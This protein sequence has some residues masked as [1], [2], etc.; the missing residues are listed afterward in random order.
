MDDKQKEYN[1][2]IK[3]FKKRCEKWN[4]NAAENKQKLKVVYNEDLDGKNISEIQ[5][6]IVADNP[7]EKEWE[8]K[9]YLFDSRDDKKRAGYIAHETFR[10]LKLDE[11]MFL[12]LNKTPIFTPKS[13]NLN[14]Y[15]ESPILQES[16]EYMAE[17]TFNI[18]KINSSIQTIV[19]GIGDCFDSDKEKFDDGE[20]FSAYYKKIA[21]LYLLSEGEK[22]RFPIIVKHF[23]RYSFLQDFCVEKEKPTNL[24]LCE[25]KLKFDDIKKVSLKDFEKGINLLPYSKWLKKYG[26]SMVDGKTTTGKSRIK[27][28]G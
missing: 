8:N 21:E 24:K 22:P 4:K 20:L 27:K 18:N 5:Y 7:G 1:D 11:K 9:V 10:R 26:K 3:K 2:L 19:F 13:E 25:N 15:N 12:V 28:K 6:I 17:L 14:K 23:S 16:M